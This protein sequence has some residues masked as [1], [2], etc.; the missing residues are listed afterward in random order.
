M[1]R[2]IITKQM[3]LGCVRKLSGY[4]AVCVCVS[5]CVGEGV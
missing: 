1:V 4:K 5:V 2:G 3:H